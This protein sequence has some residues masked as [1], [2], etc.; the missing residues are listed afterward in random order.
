[1]FDRL[2][3]LFTQF[4]HLFKFWAVIDVYQKGVILR[5]GKF[6]REIG[7]GLH[8]LIPFGVDRTLE[9]SVVT[10]M[11]DLWPAFLTIR[12]GTTV[13]VA[14]LV[15]YNIRD[16]KRALL[17]VDHITDAIKDAVNGHVSRLVRAAS[18]EELCGP[19]FAEN[20]PKECR[21]RAWKYGVEIEDVVLTD[22][23]KTRVLGLTSN[24]NSNAT[25]VIHS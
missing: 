7:P 9:L 20:L 6:V 2:V 4:I 23:C 8:W 1:V 12:D 24:G 25:Q 10:K 13:S 3:E 15:R 21:K 19:E 18:W 16:V 5:L 22:L 17:E 11:A 14:V